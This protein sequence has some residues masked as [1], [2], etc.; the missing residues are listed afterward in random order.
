MSQA[1]REQST[2]STSGMDSRQRV[3]GE[4]LYYVLAM[5][6]KH[7]ALRLLMGVEP[8]NGFEG[9]R[10]LV[11]TMEPTAA[12]HLG[13][14]SQ[15][16]APDLGSA[17]QGQAAL[18]RFGD[19]LQSWENNLEAYSRATGNRIPEEILTA[20]LVQRAPSDI[21]HYLLLNREPRIELRATEGGDSA[22]HAREESLV[23]CF[24]STPA[25]AAATAAAHPHGDRCLGEGPGEGGQTRTR[26]R[27]KGQPP[28]GPATPRRPAEPEGE[29]RSWKGE[30][31]EAGLPT[32][33]PTATP[34]AAPVCWVLWEVWALGT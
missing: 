6:L 28:E 26:Q 25:Q 18:D 12:G 19:L 1:A 3:L 16:L 13:L 11:R 7:K 8:G 27:G 2:I 17:L 9:W 34:A 5:I 32:A 14:L 24:S 21:R 31:G 10:V 23:R 22:I 33:T 30:G 4:T 29:R 20:T 15:V